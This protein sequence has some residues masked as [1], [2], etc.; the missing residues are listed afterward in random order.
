VHD[1][2]VLWDTAINIEAFPDPHTR[3]RWRDRLNEER[4]KRIDAYRKK[5]TGPHS[6]WRVWHA[7]LPGEDEVRGIALQRM[8]TWAAFLDPDGTHSHH[9]SNLALELYDGLAQSGVIRRTKNGNARQILEAAALMHDVGSAAS[10][11]AH[12]KTSAKL[13]RKL[14]APL[15][16]TAGELR[17]VSLVARYHRGALP[18]D[19]HSD[20][21][22]ISK[23]RKKR[24]LLL[25][26]ILRLACACDREHNQ[27]IRN[28]QVEARGTLVEIRAEGL[29]ELSP[30]AQHL[31]SA[32]YLLEV[33]CQRPVSVVPREV[34]AHLTSIKAALG[35]A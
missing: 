35:A 14:N 12:H 1:F 3:R 21:A 16:W 33:A 9:V 5:M 4:M 31:A 30:V 28:L 34:E 17:L 25:G 10:K 24:V 15:G 7:A 20:F 13:I 8:Q 19:A 2:D 23:T 26:G 6:L 11:Q 27:Q 32:R 22:A 18:G 29:S